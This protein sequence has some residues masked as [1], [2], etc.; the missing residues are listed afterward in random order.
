MAEPAR[1]P[2]AKWAY[3]DVS[4]LVANADTPVLHE[5]KGVDP[6]TIRWTPMQVEGAATIYQGVGTRN[7]AT[8]THI[9]LRA[10]AVPSRARLLLWTE[11]PT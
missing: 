6:E 11:H 10:T 1:S 5:F 7:A 3:R 8:S 9:W 2:Y 4:F